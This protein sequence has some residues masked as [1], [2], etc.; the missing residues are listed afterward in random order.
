MC[1]SN[2]PVL[3]RAEVTLGSSAAVDIR[4]APPS[5]VQDEGRAI[6]SMVATMALLVPL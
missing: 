6:Q 3:A 2:C 1:C 4:L 5:K